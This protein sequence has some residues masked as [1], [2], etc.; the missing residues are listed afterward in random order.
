MTSRLLVALIAIFAL[1]VTSFAQG[2]GGGRGQGGRGI[3]GMRGGM[4]SPLALLR[5]NDVQKDIAL[6]EEQKGKLTKL[7][8]EAQAKMQEA[9]EQMQGGGG[10]RQA[11]MDAMRKMNEDMG[12][13]ANEILTKEQQ[14]RLKEIAIQLGGSRIAFR[15][16]IAKE[17]GITA[18]QKSKYERLQTDQRNAM[19]SVLEKVQNGELDREEVPA[20][21]E[22]NNK[23][24]DAEV[25]KI[26]TQ[27]QKDKLKEMSGKPFKA[28]DQPRGGGG[29]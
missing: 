27:A 16:D 9:R 19:Q 14:K 25:D 11:M 4:D 3:M 17:L 10:D 7:Q 13:K 21:R 24:M 2:G 26:L 22:K 28:E 1:A 23:A 15:D 12:K 8:E 5:R 20:I 29:N 18:D 6:T